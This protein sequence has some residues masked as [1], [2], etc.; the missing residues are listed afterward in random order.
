MAADGQKV[1]VSYVG[2]YDDGE[3][4]DSTQAHGGDPLTFIVGAGQVIPG[5]DAAVRDLAPGETTTVAIEPKDAYGEYN[6]TLLRSFG[7]GELGALEEQLK[8]SAGDYVYLQDGR[9]NV[10]EVKVVSV[11]DDGI[12]LD[13]N[14][15]MAGKRLNF[16]IT[17]ESVE[18]GE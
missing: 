6:E 12:T 4:F 5:F 18:D 9:G 16:D 8:G 2:R 3:V 17:L 7:P 15:R 10:Q 1:S 13:F 14:H 11:G